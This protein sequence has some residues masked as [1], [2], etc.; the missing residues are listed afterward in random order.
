MEHEAPLMLSVS[1]ARGLIGKSMTPEV[2]GN[3]AAAFGTEIRSAVNG[4]PTI[5]IGNDGRSSAPELVQAAARS[6]AATGCS[7]IDLGTVTTPTVG[8]MIDELD[9]QGAIVVTASHNPIEWNGIKCLDSNGLAPPPEDAGRIIERFKN[10]EFEL[11]PETDRTEPG[12]NDEGSRIHV[13]RALTIVDPD[14]IRKA[15]FTVV[16]DSVNASG[17]PAGRALLEQ[18]GCSLEHLNAEQTGVFAHPPEPTRENLSDLADH[19][20]RT[21]GTACGFAQDPDADRLAIIDENGRYIGEEYTLALTALRILQVR[22]GVPL[23]ANLSTS[24]MIDDIAAGFEGASVTRT[25]VGEANVVAGMRATNAPLGGE[26]NGGVIVADVGWVRDSIA[27]MALVL[28]L[29]AS[30]GRPLS[31]IVDDLPDYAMVK[32]KLDLSQIGGRNAIQPALDRMRTAYAGAR[33]NDA[34]GVRID[35]DEGW[36]HLRASNTEPIIRVIAESRT[37]E[38]AENLASEVASAAGLTD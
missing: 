28:E 35:L 26:G 19:I 10:L 3:L 16:L 4:T 1:G 34:D 32:R 13:E 30:D 29:M 33:I 24:R 9:A 36:A 27:A 17:G 20:G 5:L 37:T 18:L 11:I 23:A 15:G 8:V 7:V 14:L 12:S 31:R 25:A 2:A 38:A 22:G 6:L 21:Q